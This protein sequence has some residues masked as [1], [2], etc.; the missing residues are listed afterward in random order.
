VKRPGRDTD[1]EQRK[2]VA[3][4]SGEDGG[5]DAV[6][7]KIGRATMRQSRGG[8][9]VGVAVT[10]LA[11]APNHRDAGPHRREHQSTYSLFEHCRRVLERSAP[12]HATSTWILSYN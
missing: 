7:P 11:A 1:E 2:R 4:R 3:P 6:G 10:R 12:T 9:L 5:R 8:T